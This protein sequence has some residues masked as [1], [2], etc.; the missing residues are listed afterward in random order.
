MTSLCSVLNL[1]DVHSGELAEHGTDNSRLMF[2]NFHLSD[3]YPDPKSCF[4]FTHCF[5]DT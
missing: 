1:N 2:Q 3:C 4:L 5:S